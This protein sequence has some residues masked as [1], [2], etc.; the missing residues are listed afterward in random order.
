MPGPQGLRDYVRDGKLRL[1]VDDAVR[2]TLLNNTNVRLNELPVEQAR[3]DLLRSHQ[4]FDPQALASFASTRTT[5]PTFSQ[6]QGAPTLSDLEQQTG[7]GYQQSLDFGGQYQVN[8]AASRSS[9][10]SQFN[11]FNPSIFSSLNFSFSQH[12]LRNRGRTTNRLFGR[13]GHWLRENI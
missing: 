6:L 9:T 7:I 8:F 5:S 12:L 11:F 1:S 3:Y 4:A 2:L 10:N 13:V